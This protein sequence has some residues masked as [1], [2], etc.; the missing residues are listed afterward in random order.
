MKNIALWSLI[1]MSFCVFA[2]TK[3]KRKIC[4]KKSTISLKTEVDS[5]SYAIGIGFAKQLQNGFSEINSAVLV[6]AITT[7]LEKDTANFLLTDS[8]K[9]LDE[10]IQNYFLKKQQIETA[11]YKKEGEQFLSEIIKKEGV[12]KTASGLMYEI[13]EKGVGEHP[14]ATSTVKVHYHG[15]TPSGE[16]FDSSVDRGEP[17]EFPL[18]KVIKGWTEGVQLMKVGAKYKFYIPADLAYG[19]NPPQGG[20]GPIK[21][22]MPLVFEVELL[23]FTNTLDTP[24]HQ[25]KDSHNHNH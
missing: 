18:N 13:I 6:N 9:N 21:A 11:I 3:K 1:L 14:M 22:N 24:N 17:I 19:T 10:I 23:G 12:I 16:V 15:T 5:V 2:K 7:F 4:N 8:S 20:Q 25:H